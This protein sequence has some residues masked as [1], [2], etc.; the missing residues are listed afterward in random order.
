MPLIAL[1]KCCL[2]ISIKRNAVNGVA[3]RRSGFGKIVRLASC[4]TLWNVLVPKSAGG[5]KVLLGPV[6]TF[7]SP[8][9]PEPRRIVTA[10]GDNPA[11]IRADR[12]R[13]DLLFVAA[14]NDRISRRI[15]GAQITQ[16]RRLVSAA[17]DNPAVIRLIAIVV[18]GPSALA[19]NRPPMKP[20]APL[21]DC[22][23]AATRTPR[24]GC[25]TLT[26][27]TASNTLR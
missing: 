7:V 25:S 20:S 24:S 10:A 16:P 11:A 14:Q 23:S 9:E 6:K 15:Y 21:N 18:I 13:S 26:A 4:A 22:S 12:H 3:D 17:D 8:G 19:T 5:P 27:S 1:S 2:S